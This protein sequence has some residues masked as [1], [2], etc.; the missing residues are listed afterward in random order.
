MTF[1]ADRLRLSGGPR[2]AEEAAGG[3]G[4]SPLQ[5]G[6]ASIPLGKDPAV[7]PAPR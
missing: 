1:L 4:Y 5:L 7:H 6:S 3:R 2:N